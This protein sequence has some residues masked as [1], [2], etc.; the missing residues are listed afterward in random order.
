MTDHGAIGVKLWDL[1]IR[2]LLYADDLIL[3]AETRTDLQLQMNL[4][5]DYANIWD[6]EINNEKTNVLVSTKNNR[7]KTEQWHIKQIINGQ[8][9]K[10]NID[11]AKEYTYLGVTFSF[12]G[13]FIDVLKNKGRKA[14]FSLLI[15]SKQWRG[16][17]PEMF[18]Y[19]ITW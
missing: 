9:V 18:I 12:S 1:Y 8:E 11:E 17:D 3:L 16:M 19:L 2:S 14:F 13:S 6:M 4:L 10:V 5:S 15:K 7:R